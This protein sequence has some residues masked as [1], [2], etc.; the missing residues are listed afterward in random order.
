MAGDNGRTM[1]KQPELTP[2]SVQRVLDE[3]IQ[4]EWCRKNGSPNDPIY[5]YTLTSRQKR[6]FHSGCFKLAGGSE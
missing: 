6:Y 1:T 5:E 3:Q 2:H 4:C